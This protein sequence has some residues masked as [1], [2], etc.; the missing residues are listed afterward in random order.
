MIRAC[1]CDVSTKRDIVPGAGPFCPRVSTPLLEKPK[2]GWHGVLG[3][4][5]PIHP[6]MLRETSHARSHLSR[7]PARQIKAQPSVADA[8]SGRPSARVEQA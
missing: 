6:Q 1:S 7:P 4:S 3:A 5:K 8:R 2:S